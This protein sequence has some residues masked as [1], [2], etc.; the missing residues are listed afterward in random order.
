MSWMFYTLGLDDR[1]MILVL[2]H[3]VVWRGEG[4]KTSVEH[5]GSTQNGVSKCLS[6]PVWSGY[7]TMMSVFHHRLRED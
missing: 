4:A 6:L 7:D 1:G 5:V 2:M 3:P